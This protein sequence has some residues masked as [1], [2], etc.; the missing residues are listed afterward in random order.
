MIKFPL[1][2]AMTKK[3][4]MLPLRPW[5]RKSR[6]VKVKMEGFWLGSESGGLFSSSHLMSA[7]GFSRNFM[8]NP[9]PVNGPKIGS[10]RHP[11]QP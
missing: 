11:L 7:T 4:A 5:P 9:K 2:C 8:L 1:F 6:D 10:H 3:A